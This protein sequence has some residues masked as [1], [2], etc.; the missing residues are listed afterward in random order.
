MIL[1]GI[2]TGVIGK[3]L[4]KEAWN[5]LS[6]IFRD[7]QQGKISAEEAQ[8]KTL[9]VFAQQVPAIEQAHSE[10]LA[11]TFA[12]F[13]GVMVQSRLVRVVWAIVTL[14]QAFV[15]FWHQFVIPFIV[16]MQ[17]TGIN[18]AT[19]KANPYPSSGATVEWAYAL[20]FG[21]CGLGAIAMRTGPAS[22]YIKQL[23]DAIRR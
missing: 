5:G 20:V 23:R 7:Y 17:W 4:V 10:S 15:L 9:Q 22:N 19:G 16:F 1:S 13:M 6:G 8:Q 12:S 14:Q 2:L 11:Q 21:L 18:P 3:T